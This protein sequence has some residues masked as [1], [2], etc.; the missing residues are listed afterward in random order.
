MTALGTTQSYCT[1]S[2]GKEVQ[3]RDQ[4]VILLF[5]HRMGKGVVQSERILKKKVLL[6]CGIISCV[7]VKSHIYNT[8]L[9]NSETHLP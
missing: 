9:G 7:S 6:R 5:K 1:W 4:E 8:L 2:M 3:P